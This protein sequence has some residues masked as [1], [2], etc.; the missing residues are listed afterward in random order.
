MPDYDL[1]HIEFSHFSSPQN[2]KSHNTGP[3]PQY[4]RR[5]QQHGIRIANELGAA[6]TTADETRPTATQL[7]E[8]SPAPSGSYIRVELNEEA[9]H[10][11]VER[12]SEKTRQSAERLLDNGARSVVLYVPDES[13]ELLTA[14]VNDYSGNGLT[15]AGNPLQAKRVEPI[16]SVRLANLV[17]LWREEPETL[18]DD[19][20]L[21]MWWAV[22][23]WPDCVDDVRSF[24]QQLGASIAPEE[25]WA[26]FPEAIVVPVYATRSAIEL[27][28]FGGQGGIAELGSATDN[29]T[30]ILEDLEPY[31]DELVTNLAERIVWP[32][33]DANAVCVLDTGVNRGHP[34][35]EPALSP[36][37]VQSIDKRWGGDDHSRRGHGTGMAGLCLHGDLTTPLGDTSRPALL[38]R[39]ESVKIL[40]PAEFPENEPG[41]YGAITASATSL[42]EIENPERG[43]LFCSAVS[44]ENKSGAKP[45]QWSASIDQI[46]SGYDGTD[47]EDQPRRLFIQ[48][49]GNIPPA[50]NWNEIS[51]SDAF[52]GEDPSQA[53]NAVTVGGVSFQNEI[54][55]NGYDDY[56]VAAG[57]G[58]V[59]PYSRN[60]VLW[61]AGASPVKPDVVFEAG[62]RAI[63]PGNEPVFDGLPSL[64]VV[65]TGKGGSGNALSP[66]WATSA[67][68]AQAARFAAKVSANYPDYWPETVR[69]VMAHSAR[70]T[71][72]MLNA[73]GGAGGLT[74]RSQ[75]R[76]RFGYGVP[77]IA[78]AMHSASSDLA[79]VSQ[80][81]IQ[82][83]KREGGRDKFGEAHY[84]DLPWPKE[85]LEEL[86]NT[87]VRL[88]VALS[89]FVE[90][91]PRSS[92]SIDA[93]R[94]R[95]FGL[96]FDLQRLGESD[97]QFRRH[98]NAEFE[99]HKPRRETDTG[100]DFGPSA[101][102]AGSL[103]VDTWEGP[104]VEL[105]S[106]GQLCVFPV[107]GWWRER[108]L[109]GR[110]NS[111][112]R[113]ALV[114]GLEA[115]NLEID[116]YTPISTAVEVPVP[117]GVV[118]IEI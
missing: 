55:E 12:K 44:N 114:L 43:R 96:R 81:Y 18:P 62:N 102:S 1:P 70:W 80:A 20:Q 9:G 14:V 3:R 88:R 109:L 32:P 82:P 23:C 38:H 4:G 16:E 104:A 99:G 24:A 64:S 118:P 27:L 110:I 95:S 49:I 30:V 85:M 47:S 117:A 10:Q 51:D 41:N 21:S 17:E 26:E 28:I 7:P 61:P 5:R 93:A 76:R 37:D 45:T 89:Y 94:Y 25:R 63:G 106:R 11:D 113:Y 107:M 65:T 36:N 87:T 83:F 84:Y 31:E 111:K 69:A 71:P 74:G 67:A 2:Y 73:L 13:R 56:S 77:D 75:L 46:A 19:P 78:R 22:W 92:A 108:R 66:F 90:P 116:L 40:P 79:L 57:V 98:T 52:P 54:L 115:P 97:A 59:S 72:V 91:N 100:W 50:G 101:I 53:W 48:T 15:D 39:L 103:H 8:G 105:A 42:A 34:L 58:A 68:T 60:S 35:I 29:P 6:F 33:N 86:Q 112:A